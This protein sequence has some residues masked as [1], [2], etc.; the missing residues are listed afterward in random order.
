VVIGGLTTVVTQV[1]RGHTPID[2]AAYLSI[3]S[4]VVVPG[5]IFMPALV[6]ALNVLLRNKYVAYVVAVGIGAGLFYLYGTGHNHWLYNPLLYRLWTYAD[7]MSET[8]LAYRLYCL[9]LA[10][11]FIALAH[12]FSSADPDRATSYLPTPP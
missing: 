10:A 4:I 2:F 11:A 9:T 7:L 3:N 6:V 12:S 8:I 5:I 1:L